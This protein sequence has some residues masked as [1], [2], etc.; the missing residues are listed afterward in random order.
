MPEQSISELT[1]RLSVIEAAEKREHAALQCQ[2]GLKL[3]ALQAEFLLRLESASRALEL[4]RTEL[5]RRLESLNNE[6]DRVK[7]IQ[8]TYA[9][10]EVVEN[11]FKEIRLIIE[12]QAREAH[13]YMDQRVDKVWSSCEAEFKDIQKA[14]K[15][16]NDFRNNFLGKQAV[17]AF[18]IALVVS[19]ALRYL[20][21]IRGATP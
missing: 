15:E 3:S 4:A 21:P 11:N 5:S 8:D 2:F 6:A 12:V 17:V 9:L 18:L 20:I 7:K 10:R 16:L 1:T 13:S 19:L 14:V